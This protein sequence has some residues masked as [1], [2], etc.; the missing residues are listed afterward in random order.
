MSIIPYAN[1]MNDL[2]YDEPVDVY[3]NVNKKGVVYSIRQDGYVVAHA[4]ELALVNAEFIVKE[5]GRKRVRKTG[6][7]NVHAWVRGELLRKLEPSENSA[8]RTRVLYNPK[9]NDGFVLKDGR[10]AI[11]SAPLV[12]LN[13]RGVFVDTT[14]GL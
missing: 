2:Y 12:L 10:L 4:T 3:R 9:K 7:K 11:K 13:E 8:L 14:V 1:R 5:A 6:R